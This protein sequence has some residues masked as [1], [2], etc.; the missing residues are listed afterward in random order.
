VP[1][2][3]GVY[4]G[5]ASLLIRGRRVGVVL[6]KGE[7]VETAGAGVSTGSRV[8]SPMEDDVVL[9]DL[10]DRREAKRL[11]GF[12]LPCCRYEYESVRQFV[13]DDDG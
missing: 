8:D 6:A 3:A 5:G 2:A 9:E 13:V 1:L 12:I 10:D 11:N 7:G 4:A